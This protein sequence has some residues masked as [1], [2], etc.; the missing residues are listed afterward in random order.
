MIN[1]LN[2]HHTYDCL[3]ALYLSIYI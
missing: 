1:A 3:V 2:T